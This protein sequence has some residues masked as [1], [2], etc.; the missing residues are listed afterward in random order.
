MMTLT[1]DAD[2]KMTVDLDAVDAVEY[3]CWNPDTSFDHDVE[4]ED[5]VVVGGGGHEEVDVK[6]QHLQSNNLNLC[7]SGS[8]QQLVSPSITT[9]STSSRTS[10]S[11]S[12]SALEIQDEGLRSSAGRGQHHRGHHRARKAVEERRERDE[13]AVT[14]ST[15]QHQSSSTTRSTSTTK[16]KPKDDPRSSFAEERRM[17]IEERERLAEERQKLEIALAKARKHDELLHHDLHHAERKV[18]QKAEED[19][20]PRIFQ[21][22]ESVL[23]GEDKNLWEASVAARLGVGTLSNSEFEERSQRELRRKVK[24]LAELD[25]KIKEKLARCFSELKIVEHDVRVEE[26]RNAISNLI[27][28]ELSEFKEDWRRKAQEE[29]DAR[30]EAVTLEHARLESNFPVFVIGDGDPVPL[31]A[32]GDDHSLDGIERFIASAEA[33]Q[34]Q[35]RKPTSTG[36]RPPHDQQA[37]IERHGRGNVRARPPAPGASIPPVSQRAAASFVSPPKRVV[38]KEDA[39]EDAELE[40]LYARNVGRLAR[41]ERLI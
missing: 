35:Q 34:L 17:L 6:G 5:A 37:H 12:H 25:T 40:L 19:S 8:V 23:T 36:F 28:R 26:E 9:S 31:N 2:T 29:R 10:E 16:M 11:R 27:T 3:E 7:L 13:V 22:V 15:H 1:V 33:G 38:M 20:K 4:D 14:V 32:D 39:E 18:L 24:E 21:E 30:T 41:L